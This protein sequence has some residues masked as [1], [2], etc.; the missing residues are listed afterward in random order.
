L[1][2]QD[3]L[4]PAKKQNSAGRRR[5]MKTTVKGILVGLAMV[6]MLVGIAPQ[7]TLAQQAGEVNSNGQMWN[8]FQWVTPGAGGNNWSGGPSAFFEPMGQQYWGKSGDG[9]V[10][11][12]NPIRYADDVRRGPNTYADRFTY[13]DRNGNAWV[14]DGFRFISYGTSF[15][16]SWCPTYVQNPDGSIVPWGKKHPYG[17]GIQQIAQHKFPPFRH[18]ARP[19]LPATLNLRSV[20][21]G[22]SKACVK[23]DP[24]TLKIKDPIVLCPIPK[25]GPTPPGPVRNATVD[26]STN[27]LNF[28]NSSGFGSVAKASARPVS[29]AQMQARIPVRR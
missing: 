4:S 1:E 6:G 10:L 14:W 20:V 23:F 16:D 27:A 5:K 24:K 2:E 11:L 3:R 12:P 8:G 17:T 22:S 29:A 9:W 25:P 13:Q 28:A 7:M 21:T 19:M 15:K 26:I 18:G